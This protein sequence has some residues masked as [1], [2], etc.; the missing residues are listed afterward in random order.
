ML[1]A[2]DEHDE[3]RAAFAA[4]VAGQIALTLA[5]GRT[6]RAYEDATAA[7]RRR[8]RLLQSTLDAID[9]PILVLDPAYRTT[10][11]NRAAETMGL[12]RRPDDPRQWPSALSLFEPDQRTPIRWDQMP[13][14]RALEGGPV[15]RAE[16]VALPNGEPPV[17]LSVHARA[18]QSED[19]GTESAVAVLRDVTAEKL[20]QMHHVFADRMASLGVLAAGIAHEINNPLGVVVAELDMAL[21][22]TAGT[23]VHTGLALAREGVDRVRVIVRDLK[24]LSRGETEEVELLDLRRPIEAALRMASAETRSRASIVRE[25]GEVPA[26]AA[27]EARLGQVFL[28]LIV[29][30]AHAIPKGKV[31]SH[32]ITVRTW[33]DAAQVYAEVLDTGS[34][35]T[36]EVRARLFT[37]FFTTKEIGVGSGLGLSVSRNIVTAAGG[38]IDVE[39]S[40]GQGS[41]FRLRFPIAPAPAPR[42]S[43]PPPAR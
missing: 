43:Q 32:R 26:I 15:V 21:E 4:V 20:A 29:N 1:G 16:M 30:A 12:L 25:L 31:A 9:D 42:R 8:V 38:H 36:P 37:P 28:N 13:M 3:H 23:P 2:G 35:M 27:N 11:W 41:T 19:G 34:G 6:I 18:V 33:A 17:W 40:L 39:S 14:I 24:T 22:D 10:H 7:E 5:M